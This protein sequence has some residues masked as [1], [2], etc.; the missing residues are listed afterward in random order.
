MKHILTI[1]ILCA[2]A[3]QVNAQINS[4]T[5]YIGGTVGGSV[6]TTTSD[7]KTSSFNVQP[8]VG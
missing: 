7:Y 1:L 2:F 8:T 5:K 6:R 4:G 3:L